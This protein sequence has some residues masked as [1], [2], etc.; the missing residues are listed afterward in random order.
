M[1]AICWITGLLGLLVA[2]YLFL[3]FPRKP[4]RPIQDLQGWDYAHRGLWNDE[5]PEN[6]LPAFRNA[7]ANGF[8]MELDVHI[9]AD[10]ELV[11]FHDDDLQR[12]CGDARRVSDCTLRELKALRL[13]DTDERI[14]TFDEFLQTVNGQ[15]P[16]IIELKSDKNLIRLCEKV[17]ERLRRYNGVYCSESFHPLAVR[18]WRKNRPDVIRG[19]LTLGLCK[20]S[21]R[22]KTGELRFLASMAV[23][24]L[25]RPDFVAMETITDH[26]VPIRIQR[27]LRPWLVAWTVKSQDEMDRLR[28]KY[29]LQIFDSFVPRKGRTT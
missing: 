1:Q 12:M 3:C 8:G 5:L 29:D 17:E 18:W 2:L 28:G 27:L 25:S 23:N 26:S 4:R 14:P 21:E 6:S 24:V 13:L 19:Q 22:E 16:L 7:I 11:V 10:D 15:A 9:T 20:P